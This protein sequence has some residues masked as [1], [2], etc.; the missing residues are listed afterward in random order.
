VGDES[1]ALCYAFMAVIQILSSSRLWLWG[2]WEQLE[3]QD[4]PCK[5]YYE[6]GRKSGVVRWSALQVAGKALGEEHWAS[7]AG[8]SRWSPGIR[9]SMNIVSG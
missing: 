1:A 7:E 3:E 4:G 2:V 5:V 6:P 8:G 9:F